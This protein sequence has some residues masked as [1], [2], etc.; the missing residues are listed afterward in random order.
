M[1][2]QV[3][4]SKVPLSISICQEIKVYYLP[5][6]LNPAQPAFSEVL[7]FALWNL[8]TGQVLFCLHGWTAAGLHCTY[9]A[10]SATLSPAF[11]YTYHLQHG[12]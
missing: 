7:L 4:L 11:A 9:E 1:Y 5:H 10:F 8:R 2:I 12:K 6:H 3:K